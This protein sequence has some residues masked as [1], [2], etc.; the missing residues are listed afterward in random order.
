[1][2]ALAVG[3]LY[4]GIFDACKRI[5]CTAIVR[6]LNNVIILKATNSDEN[7]SSVAIALKKNN[8]VFS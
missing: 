2:S 5:V 3:R 6:D 1:M 7:V 8:E 4:K